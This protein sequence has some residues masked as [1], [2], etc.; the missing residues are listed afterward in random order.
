M[1]RDMELVRKILF[2][3]EENYVAGEKWLRDIEIEEYDYAVIMEHA[4]LAYENGLIQDIKDISTLG[5][6]SYWVGNLSNAGYDF[7]DIIRSD[8]VWNKTKTAI[9]EK[10][11][12]MVTGTISTIA[13]AFISAAA[14]G[15]AN[16]ILKSGGIL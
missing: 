13:N 9:K 11:L 3:I 16:S 1:K 8:T 4:I 6:T 5:G 15:V 12:P 14:E 10:G 7:L 2:Y